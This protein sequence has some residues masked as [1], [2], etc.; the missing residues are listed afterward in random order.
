MYSK[1]N[2]EPRR[3]GFRLR[4]AIRDAGIPTVGTWEF[5]GTVTSERATS[6]ARA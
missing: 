2:R 1:R 6:F 4:R 5:Y 3:L